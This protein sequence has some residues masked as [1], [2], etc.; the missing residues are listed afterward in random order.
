MTAM[1]VDGL[2]SVDAR[3]ASRPDPAI[4]Y[5]SSSRPLVAQLEAAW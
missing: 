2:K 1:T 4:G 3:H 5:A